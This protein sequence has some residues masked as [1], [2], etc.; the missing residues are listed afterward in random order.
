M[1][2][3]P[4]YACQE[5][6]VMCKVPKET[7]EKVV[8]WVKLRSTRIDRGGTTIPN[9]PVNTSCHLCKQNNKGH[10]IFP[11]LKNNLHPL[12]KYGPHKNVEG[13]RKKKK[14]L[15]L[16]NISGGDKLTEVVELIVKELKVYHGLL[17]DQNKLMKEHN[18][19]MRAILEKMP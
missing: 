10:C 17:R 8:K 5:L 19:L 7:K 3:E 12:D 11:F 1:A 18:E 6:N 15:E 13:S 4:C 16:I 14:Q 2:D 9:R